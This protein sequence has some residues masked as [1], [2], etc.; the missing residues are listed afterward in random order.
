MTTTLGES[1]RRF[2]EGEPFEPDEFQIEA[3]RAIELGAS[4]VVTAPT[5]SGKTLIAE[6]AAEIALAAGRRTFYTAP[7]KALS[8]QK[9]HDLVGRYGEEGVGLLTGDNTINGEAP[10]VVM[11][12]EVLRNMIYAD[13]DAL[14]GLGVVILD[15]VHYLQDRYRGSVWEEVIIHLPPGIQLVN[16]SATIANPKEFTDWIRAR[17]GT[18][19]LVVEERRPVP[20]ESMYLLRDRHHGD[21]VEWFPVFSKDGLHPNKRVLN[22]LRKGRGR[23]RRFATPR[24]LEVSEALLGAGKLPAIYFIF[25][26]AGC[27]QAARTVAAAGLRLTSADEREEIRS[28]AD[29]ATAHLDPI[30]LGVL[31]YDSW[32][33]TLEAGVAAHHAG[34]VPAFKET[35]EQLFSS[36]HIKLVFATETLSLGI[37]MPAKAVVLESF[38]KFNGETHELLRAGEFTQ[39]TGRAGRRGMDEL[40]TAVILYSSYVPFKK[41]A[42]VAAMGSHPLVSSFEP[43]Y[44]MAVNLVANYPKQQAEEL[45]RASFA[46]FRTQQRVR[47]LE[48]RIA[49]RT[50]EV[51]QFLQAAQ[52]EHGDIE[53]YAD[54]P[55]GSGEG[56]DAVREFFASLDSGD[57]LELGDGERWVIL[58]RGYGRNPRYLLLSDRGERKK[59]TPD[60]LGALPMHLGRLALVEPVR[61][62]D[63]GY[64][65]ATAALLRTWV[66]DEAPRSM[67]ETEPVV[68]T[69]ATCPDLDEHL[70]WLARSHRA[71]KDLRRLVRRRTRSGDDVVD[72]FHA[73]MTVLSELGYVKRWDLSEKGRSLRRVYNE[74]DLLLTEAVESGALEEL[75]A[76]EFAAVVSMFT[77][78]PRVT[79]GEAAM[80]VGAI[81]HRYEQ[82]AKI[83]EGVSSAEERHRVP[84][85]RMPEPGFAP[86]AYGWVSG[87]GLDDLFG[88]DGFAAGDFVRNCRQLLDLMRQIRDAF[89]SLAPVAAA[90][91]TATD[92][93]IVAVGGRA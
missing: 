7:I 57:V 4:V 91:I 35:V 79:D 89:P 10:V 53:A 43:S 40:G 27:D 65:D 49:E 20:L 47:L 15:E 26:R 46:Q 51:A 90:A 6:A 38:S 45:L 32:L 41:V 80:L 22:L 18:T 93:G 37:N 28:F 74:L 62:S 2:L 30:D 48:D 29:E 86:Y 88:E 67:E 42:D 12:T 25:S 84:V 82:I 36:G 16:L 64:L 60:E 52:C 75:S 72:R 44:N 1:A 17:R 83:W 34:M 50:A 9:Y 31:G 54:A 39:L 58:V 21:A 55:L 3:I 71:S 73:R 78:E 19:E 59:A 85:S 5:G 56:S 77:F 69:V 24:R 87:A 61:S 11:T 76:A 66:P 68:A 92:R 23:H 63:G 70:Q 81:A 8:N 33:T 13:S 14:E